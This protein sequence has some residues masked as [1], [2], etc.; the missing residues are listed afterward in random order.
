ME[1]LK[2]RLNAYYSMI[3]QII[4]YEEKIK[5]LEYS[6]AVGGI[7]YDKITGE[8]GNRDNELI[9]YIERKEPYEQV[10]DKLYI[11]TALLRAELKLDTLDK[12]ELSLLEAVHLE[13]KTYEK[14]AEDYHYSNKVVIFR[15]LQR[16]YK[17]LESD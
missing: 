12:E 7:S 2:T 15:K 16:I 6:M 8:G 3:R 4:E 14:I 1:R 9:R 11:E 17:K 5:A 13:R 10:L